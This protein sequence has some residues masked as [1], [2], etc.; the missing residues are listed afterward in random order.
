VNSINERIVAPKRMYLLFI[1][2]SPLHKI[3]R[4]ELYINTTATVN[5]LSLTRVEALEDHK[6]F[7]NI[8]IKYNIFYL[9]TN[10]KMQ[11]LR[12]ILPSNSTS[13]RRHG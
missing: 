11:S 7:E 6:L 1:V 10:T 12:G 9:K 13:T 4:F 2:A 3:T 8:G 5:F